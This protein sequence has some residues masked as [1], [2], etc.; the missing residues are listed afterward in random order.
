M[1]LPVRFSGCILREELNWRKYGYWLADERAV[2]K[3]ESRVWGKR[4]LRD[5]DNEALLPVRDCA[6][7]VLCYFHLFV[8]ETSSAALGELEH[9][10]VFSLY[11]LQS[12]RL[13]AGRWWGCKNRNRVGWKRR[14]RDKENEAL[15][16]VRDCP[17]SVLCYFHLFVEGISSVALEDRLSFNS[18]VQRI[19]CRLDRVLQRLQRVTVLGTQQ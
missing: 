19:T 17:V 18:M 12:S 1:A 13:L 16:P 6:V 11:G 14:L 2:K 10:S 5:K 9:A 4:Q 3:K 8:E 7:S 15:L